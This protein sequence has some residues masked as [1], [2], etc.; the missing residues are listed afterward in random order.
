MKEIKA[1]IKPFMSDK[2]IQAMREFDH[3][4]GVTVAKV[5]G[6]GH[7]PLEASTE[8]SAEASMAKLEIVV[9]DGL[10]ETVV[11]L[12]AT[13]AHTGNPGDGLIFVTNVE[14]VVRIQTGAR[15]EEA[16][17]P[18]APEGEGTGD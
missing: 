15:G 6:F 8:A 5:T 18:D 12:V 1:I 10:A 4:P 17:E 7:Q 13:A 3:L 11:A 14:E 9:P 2:V 16:L